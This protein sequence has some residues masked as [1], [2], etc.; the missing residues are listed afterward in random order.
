[1]KILQVSKLLVLDGVCRVGEFHWVEPNIG[2]LAY[3]ATKLPH[4]QTNYH[5][6]S[7]MNTGLQA[8]TIDL[9]TFSP[10]RMQALGFKFYIIF[11]IILY[12]ILTNLASHKPS[13]YSD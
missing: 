9:R 13:D 5:P 4:G 7:N 2:V 12:Y 6:I 8:N 1:M 3:Y 10:C 11:Y